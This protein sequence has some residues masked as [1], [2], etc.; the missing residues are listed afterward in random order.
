[1]A[2]HVFPENYG[3][4]AA[5]RRSFDSEGWPWEHFARHLQ[6]AQKEI[7]SL[8]ALALETGIPKAML[9]A[10]SEGG[11]ARAGASDI[12]LLRFLAFDALLGFPMV[13]EYLPALAGYLPAQPR[14]ESG[15]LDGKLDECVEICEAS[16][17]VFRQAS[18]KGSLNALSPSARAALRDRMDHVLKLAVTVVAELDAIQGG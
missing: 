17:G 9:Y 4:P 6:L 10:Y 12:P 18:E 1:M 5:L 7:G 11:E 15:E 16:A 2:R 13:T 8:D 14:P 3:F